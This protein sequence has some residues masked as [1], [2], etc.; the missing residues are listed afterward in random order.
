VAVFVALCEGYL[1]EVA[2]WDLWILL[3]HGELYTDSV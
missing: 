3:F 2:Y 1:G